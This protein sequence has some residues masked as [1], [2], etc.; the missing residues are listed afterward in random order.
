MVG[1]MFGAAAPIVLPLRP[2][3]EQDTHGGS[4]LKST[5]RI[6]RD[7]DDYLELWHVNKWVGATIDS[8]TFNVYWSSAIKIR[9]ARECGGSTRS[10]TSQP[11]LAAA[12]VTTVDV[13][14]VNKVVFD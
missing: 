13:V 2:E 12:G 14:D 8:A 9:A 6:T 3:E 7:S 4:N 11:A 1:E 10:V 5:G